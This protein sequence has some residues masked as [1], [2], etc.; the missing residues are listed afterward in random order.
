MPQLRGFGERAIQRGIAT[1]R[2]SGDLGMPATRY[3]YTTHR[4]PRASTSLGS[5][6][7]PVMK[8]CARTLPSHRCRQRFALLEAADD[9]PQRVQREMAYHLGPTQ[10]HRRG[11]RAVGGHFGDDLLIRKLMCPQTQDSLPERAFSRTPPQTAHHREE[12]GLVVSVSVVR[13]AVLHPGKTRCG[14]EAAPAA[15]GCGRTSLRS[16]L[17]DQ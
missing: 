14:P 11:R 6:S 13:R 1:R 12:S 7:G 8:G 5:A 2:E 10:F 3:R 9:R 4:H 17:L 15:S 16:C